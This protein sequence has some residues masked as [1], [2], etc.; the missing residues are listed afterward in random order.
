MDGH[1][2]V[3]HLADLCMSGKTTDHDHGDIVAQ[4][5]DTYEALYWLDPNAVPASWGFRRGAAP[6][7]DYA[8]CY[9]HSV[10]SDP[11]MRCPDHADD[12]W[13]ARSILQDLGVN[14][15]DPYADW[16]NG[17]CAERALVYAGTVMC[18]YASLIRPEGER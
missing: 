12:C 5:F 18:R 17:L 3:H 1:Q 16:G 13:A 7:P 10:N 2:L 6:D 8:Q 15:T 11:E 14:I 9:A 4:C